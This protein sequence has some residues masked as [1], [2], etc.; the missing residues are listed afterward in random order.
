MPVAS[1]DNDPPRSLPFRR[2]ANCRVAP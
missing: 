2:C 1:C